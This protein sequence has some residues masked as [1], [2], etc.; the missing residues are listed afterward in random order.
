MKR[1]FLILLVLIY[2]TTQAQ[3]YK[4]I[5]L[6]SNLLDIFNLGIDLPIGRKI[7]IN[8]SISYFTSFLF[9]DIDINNQRIS[10]KKH[11][12][13]KNDFGYSKSTYVFIGARF[14]QA[15]SRG[16][17]KP[18]IYEIGEL[19]VKYGCIGFGNKSRR[20]DIWLEFS[21]IYESKINEIYS[22]HYSG[23]NRMSVRAWKPE[24]SIRLGIA[25]NLINVK[26]IK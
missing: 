23:G 12:K 21:K 9:Q 3:S 6:Q 7:T 16:E 5:T 19:D 17:I 22:I 24:Y 1:V 8:G 10:I 15:S 11:F 20:F 2:N 4:S 14:R 26:I 18:N 13:E 25:V